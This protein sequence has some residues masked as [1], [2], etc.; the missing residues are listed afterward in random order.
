MDLPTCP[1]CG[2]SVLDDDAEECPFCG[3]SM[4]ARPLA[5]PSEPANAAP[6]QSAAKKA[7]QPKA[8]KAAKQADETDG[9]SPFEIDAAATKRAIPLNAKPSKGKL[10]RVICPMCDTPGFTAKKA[11]GMDVRCANPE[12]LMPIFPAP[13]IEVE[14][15]PEEEA[16][17]IEDGPPKQRIS[18]AVLIGGI[19][20]VAVIGVGVGAL[21]YSSSQPQEL[22]PVVPVKPTVTKTETPKEKTTQNGE[23]PATTKESDTKPEPPKPSRRLTWDD[24]RES[25]LPLMVESSQQRNNNR[26]KPFCRRKT[27]DAYAQFGDFDAVKHQLDRLEKVGEAVPYY[28]IPPLVTMA[29]KRLEQGDRPSADEFA[30]RALTAAED[31]PGFGLFSV[32]TASGLAAVL[33]AL[34]RDDDARG[35]LKKILNTKLAGQVAAVIRSVRDLQ[36]YDFDAGMQERPLS[37]WK[38]PEWVATTI[39]LVAHGR[40]DKALKFAQSNTDVEVRND[41]V[42][43]WSVT[44]VKIASTEAGAATLAQID[45]AAGKLDAAARSRLYANVAWLQFRKQDQAAVAISLQKAEQAISSVAVPDE[46]FLPGLDPTGLKQFYQ[47]ELPDH[48]PLQTAAFAWFEIAHLQ[49]ALKQTEAAW[50]SCQKGLAFLRGSTPNTLQVVPHRVEVGGRRADGVR[51]QLQIILELDDN[52]ARAAVERYK[53]KAESM[54][55]VAKRRFR[56]QNTLM[57]QAIDWGLLDDVWEEV[58]HRAVREPSDKLYEPFRFKQISKLMLDRYRALGNANKVKLLEDFTQSSSARIP[59][60]QT[61]KDS[62]IAIE[63]GK[64]K[65]AAEVIGRFQTVEDDDEDWR[66]QLILRFAIRLVNKQKAKQGFE[67][68][69]R[70]RDPLIRERAFELTAARATILG[71]GNAAKSIAVRRD[72]SATEM[73]SLYRGIVAGIAARSGDAPV[74][75]TQ[76]TTPPVSIGSADP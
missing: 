43:A 45:A 39:S 71:Q 76:Q 23:T 68:I 65:E 49:A 19:A 58:R 8:D 56:I 67:F 32:E 61:E 72:L 70:F 7:S 21:I 4:S 47:L 22:L 41:C 59:R 27:A 55:V 52:Q 38:S 50:T 42:V 11:A 64:I 33:V 40:Q 20:A 34:G 48:V 36:S 35:L 14:E 10:H 53:R 5:K 73:V 12:C 30:G 15:K 60:A 3:V 13:P 9:E 57:M 63:L 54:Q 26:S 69:K 18:A 17:P 37:D 62:T 1:T 16:E 2:Q 51:K 29:W 46:R 6:K 28:Q 75:K 31:L 66:D 25:I 74:Q 24:V 44:Q